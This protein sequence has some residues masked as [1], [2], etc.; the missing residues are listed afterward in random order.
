MSKW[1]ENC[2]A[3]RLGGSFN[4]TTHGLAVA[5]LL[6][7]AFEG[8]APACT[9]TVVGYL[10]EGVPPDTIDQLIADLNFRRVYTGTTATSKY[11]S[12]KKRW[13]RDEIAL[14]LVGESLLSLDRTTKQ[15][16]VQLVTTDEALKD[17]LADSLQALLDT[18]QKR[19]VYALI[20][21]GNNVELKSIGSLSETL[22]RE[23][24][25]PSVIESFDFVAKNLA[26]KDPAGRLT[27]IN[28]PPG[29]GKTHLIKGLIN[30]VQDCQFVVVTPEMIQAITGPKL[31]TLFSRQEVP[32]V[33]VLEDADAC[34]VK[35]QADNV[36]AVQAMLNLADGIV[37]QIL[38]FRIVATTNAK[39]L[40][41]DEAIRRPGRLCRQIEMTAL[42]PAQA[43]EVY[44][45]LADGRSGPFKDYATL[46]QVYAASKGLDYDEPKAAT[47]RAGF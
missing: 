1:W 2:A 4:L 22:V 16:E 34:L 41:I 3:P 44:S 27:I 39:R 37:G 12:D 7:Q 33:F 47:P 18:K 40:D 42:K 10:K 25:D 32:T 19:G 43:N 14:Y 28:G 11:D 35:R 31:L 5:A 13:V 17:K 26:S 24:Y 8:G 45:R 15:V 21:S 46:A 36:S 30:E 23:N 20:D 6:R 38:D 9:L 29:T